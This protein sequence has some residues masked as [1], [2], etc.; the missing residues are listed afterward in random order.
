MVTWWI[1]IKTQQRN[2]IEGRM[3]IEDTM[4]GIMEDTM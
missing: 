2:N 4:E 1:N 3:K